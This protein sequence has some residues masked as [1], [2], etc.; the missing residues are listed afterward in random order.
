MAANDFDDEYAPFICQIL[1]TQQAVKDELVWQY[2]LRNETPPSDQMTSL[3]KLVLSH[4]RLTVKT[5]RYINRLIKSDSYLRS[6]DLRGNDMCT[7]AVEEL[8][9]AL[10]DNDSIFNLDLRQ[11]PGLSQKLHRLLALKML[12]NYTLIGQTI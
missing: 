10:K 5:V 7:E 9:D 12:Q 3:K 4:N 2:G 1:S 8:Y 6:L 11:N